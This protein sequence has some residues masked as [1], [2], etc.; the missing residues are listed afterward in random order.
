M[1]QIL[2]I[3]FFLSNLLS[4]NSPMKRSVLLFI[5]FSAAV[6]C[7]SSCKKCVTCTFQGAPVQVSTYC[8][9]DFPDG[10]KGLNL[11]VKGWEA[12]G[13]TCVNQ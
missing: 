13:Y 2:E 1:P 3:Q 10:T 8:S 9:K 4:L 11:T 5:I 6:F 12:Q 7:F